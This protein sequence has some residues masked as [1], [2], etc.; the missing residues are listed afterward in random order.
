MSAFCHESGNVDHGAGRE[1]AMGKQHDATALD[2]IGAYACGITAEWNCTARSWKEPMVLW[3]RL[4][5]R[6]AKLAFHDHYLSHQQGAN[7]MYCTTAIM[8]I[9][10]KRERRVRR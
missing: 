6:M 1:P 10:P 7:G 9:Y 8:T 2:K 4:P 5:G 3:P